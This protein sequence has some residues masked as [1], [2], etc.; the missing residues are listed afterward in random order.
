MA[1]RTKK[2]E[3]AETVKDFAVYYGM[4]VKAL[5]REGDSWKYSK[6]S[7]LRAQDKLEEL[8]GQKV[9]LVKRYTYNEDELLSTSL[10]DET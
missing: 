6:L 9:D 3:I 5:Q 4:M 8:L 10:T 2:Q 1:R 7:A